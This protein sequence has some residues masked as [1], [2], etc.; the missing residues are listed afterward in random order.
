[1][2]LSKAS[3]FV[4]NDSVMLIR[5]RVELNI[6]FYITD[7]I[8]QVFIWAWV[9]RLLAQIHHSC[10]KCFRLWP[11]V[12]TF[13]IPTD[14]SGGTGLF[15]MAGSVWPVRSGRFGLTVSV[16]PIR[17]EPFGL[18]LSV[19]AFRSEP[20]GLSRFGLGRFGLGLFCHGTFRSGRFDLRTFRS[21]HSCTQITSYIRLFKWF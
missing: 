10:L 21:R 9:A 8:N 3:L 7:V 12:Y 11:N 14:V 18:S 19:W 2:L 6:L 4:S 5:R 1:M 13:Y 16:W 20:F 15:G 17:S